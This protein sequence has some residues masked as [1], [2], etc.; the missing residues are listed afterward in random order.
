MPRWSKNEEHQLRQ[1]RNELAK[2]PTFVANDRPDVVGD[3]R[4]LRFLRGHEHN[5][6]IAVAKFT[7]FLQ[8]REA[9]KVD[10]V[11]LFPACCSALVC[12][13]FFIVC[14]TLGMKYYT[15]GKLKAHLIS[16]LVQKYWI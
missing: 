3:R 6:D 13:F 12:V 9:N 7:S 15:Q 8:W 1:M 11:R 10:L 2:I 16:L 4:L 14:S 5:L